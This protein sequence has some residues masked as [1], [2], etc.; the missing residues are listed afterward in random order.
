MNKKFSIFLQRWNE[1]N[2]HFHSLFSGFQAHGFPQSFV[3]FYNAASFGDSKIAPTTRM[4][5]H[6][7]MFKK[8]KLGI[9]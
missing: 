4:I 7:K 2:T 6:L 1:N 3:F 5:D 9:K 8:P